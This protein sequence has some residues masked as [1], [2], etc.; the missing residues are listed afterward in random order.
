MA[1]LPQSTPKCRSE[2]RQAKSR[3]EEQSRIRW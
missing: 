2:R 1:S 3:K